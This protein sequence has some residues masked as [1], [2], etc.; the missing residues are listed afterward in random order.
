V[1]GQR[2]AIAV[3]CEWL[4]IWRQDADFGPW[5]PHWITRD[6][7][8]TGQSRQHGPLRPSWCYGTPGLARAQQLAAIATGD[9]Y[10]QQLAEHALAAATSDP[11]QLARITDTGL[12]HGWAGLCHTVWRAARDALTPAIGANLPYI[13]DQLTRSVWGHGSGFLEG[14]A[15]VALARHT[16]T[17]DMAPVS[18]W[19]ACLLID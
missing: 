4:D 15:G 7:V 6:E 3:I 9:R 16:A 1:D 13:A 8:R 11:A 12:C 5:W 14:D 10:R 17:R 18:G 2:D 19:D